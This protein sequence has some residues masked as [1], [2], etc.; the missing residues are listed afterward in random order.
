MSDWKFLNEH[1]HKGGIAGIMQKYISEDSDGFN[2][3]FRFM[4][5]GKLI[6]CISSDGEAWQHFY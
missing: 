2:G 4:L 3:L 1:R 5:D 6:R